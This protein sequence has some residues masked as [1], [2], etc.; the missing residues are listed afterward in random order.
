VFDVVAMDRAVEPEPPSIARNAGE[1]EQ[2]DIAGSP[3][4]ENETAGNDGTRPVAFNA[5]VIV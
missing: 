5:A 1:K 4:Q 3:E 2:L